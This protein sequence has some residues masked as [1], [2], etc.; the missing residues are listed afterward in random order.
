MHVSTLTYTSAWVD[1]ELSESAQKGNKMIAMGLK[2]VIVAQLPD[3][4]RKRDNRFWFW[5]PA[6]L[7]ELI[8]ND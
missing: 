1:W 7:K 4:F 8:E 2:G 6:K 5:D 3:Y